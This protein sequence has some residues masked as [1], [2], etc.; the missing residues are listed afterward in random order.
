MNIIEAIESANELRPGNRISDDTKRKWLYSLDLKIYNEVILTHE[1]EEIS[2]DINGDGIV[3][4][5]D[6][7]LLR[8]VIMGTYI[9]S[10]KE[11]LRCDVNNDGTIDQR[12]I[13]W[14]E[15]KFFRDYLTV[16]DAKLIIPDIDSEVYVWYLV[17]QIDAATGETERY[18]MST[19]RFNLLYKAFSAR[20]NREHTPINNY[21]V[22]NVMAVG[23]IS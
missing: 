5:K 18:N 17:S 1:R 22:H 21:R 12:D 2:G 8:K 16:T 19:E 9:P 23:G 13:V 14:L 10:E 7:D 15:K 11:L 20:Y 3:D 4:E 6:K